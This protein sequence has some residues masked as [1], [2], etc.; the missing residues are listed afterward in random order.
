M[1]VLFTSTPGFG[2][3]FPMVPLAWAFRC[4]GHQVL[5]AAPTQIA[6]AVR[7]AGLEHST[8][9]GTQAPLQLRL[10]E[11]HPAGDRNFSVEPWVELAERA[12]AGTIDVVREW[13]PH[14]VI[15]D[16]ADFAGPIAATL[17]GVPKVSH[18]W[19][20]H[21]SDELL[22]SLLRGQ[23]LRR[24]HALYERVGLQ[25]QDVAPNVTIDLC[26]PSLV[27]F[28]NHGW[29]RMRHIP[30]CGA[31]IRSPW[32]WAPRSR[33]RV[34]VSMGSVPTEAGVH[35][36]RDVA[37]GLADFPG[38]VILTGAGSRDSELGEL[39]DNV[40]RG[41]WLTHDQVMPGC[42]AVIHHGGSGTVLNS[43][44]F[45]LP[46]LILPQMFDQFENA[47]RMLASGAARVIEFGDRAP[48]EVHRQLD[49]LLT[50]RSYRDEATRLRF[51]IEAMPLP[52]EVVARLETRAWL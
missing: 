31:G 40:R 41:G 43:A 46:Q 29:L 51:E 28:D 24:L 35:G 49:L 8:V 38:E 22:G 4:A 12:V 6:K 14:L 33:P 3:L 52:G 39:P 17:A 2:H 18:H 15:S 37:R 45:G 9:G 10:E 27:R 25:P 30:Y 36:L 16:F 47:E 44:L 11:A 7:S 34:C 21:V 42:D 1:R 48:D 26:P 19:G 32:L 20:L 23:T 5:V 50:R 13:R